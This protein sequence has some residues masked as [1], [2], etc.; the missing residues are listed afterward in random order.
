MKSCK[1]LIITAWA[2]NPV[3]MWGTL[4]PI[5]KN[6]WGFKV[7]STKRIIESEIAYSQRGVEY[8]TV[9]T[10]TD[11]SLDQMREFDGLI[12]VSGHR[13]PTKKMLYDER[14]FEIVK[15]FFDDDK[16]IAVPCVSVPVLRFVMKG[17]KVTAYP[18]SV[19][20]NLLKSFGVIVLKD[21][22]VVDGKIVTCRSMAEVDVMMEEFVKLMKKELQSSI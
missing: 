10:L 16:P 9:E 3:E 17:R 5:R 2:Y 18:W 8:F 21:A 4:K 11:L 20:H 19:V 1:V 12:F 22:V 6:R 13:I 7:L 14:V 15:A